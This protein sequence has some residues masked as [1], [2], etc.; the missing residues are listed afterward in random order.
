MRTG[1]G[2]IVIVL[3]WACCVAEDERQLAPLLR[4]LARHVEEERVWV[5]GSN[6]RMRRPP[7]QRHRGL[8]AGRQL[9]HVERDRLDSRSN[10]SG[11]SAPEPQKIWRT[12]SGSGSAFG[13][14]GGD[15]AHAR[16]DGEGHLD[17]LVE[18]R[19]VAVAQSEQ[20]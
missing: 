4:L 8:F 19:L 2:R 11:R 7:R 9:Q 13:I 6:T 16:V 3:A 1:P 12:Y 15:A 18:R 5:T 10:S 14:V 17:H 20:E